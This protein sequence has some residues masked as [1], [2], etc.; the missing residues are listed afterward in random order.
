MMAR[1]EEQSIG[2]GD[3]DHSCVP[4]SWQKEHTRMIMYILGRS[5]QV[6]SLRTMRGHNEKTWRAGK[7]SRE[8]ANGTTCMEH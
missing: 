3:D 4:E 5:W 6:D 2:Q 7:Q 1:A 8:T